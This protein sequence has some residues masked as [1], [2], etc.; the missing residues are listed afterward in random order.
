VR[1]V[2]GYHRYETAAELLLLNEIWHLHSKL[3]NYFYPQQKLVSK[4]RDGAKVSKKYDTATT[5]FRRAIGHQSITDHRKAVLAR[6]YASINPAAVQRQ[7][8]ALTAELL[9]L[10]TS[11]AGPKTKA[12]VPTRA[13]SNESTNQSSRA[14]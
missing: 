3:A 4:T 7:I 1:T 10:T 8:Q 5:P 12:P 9:T 2:V 6:T 13:S 11:K 14:S